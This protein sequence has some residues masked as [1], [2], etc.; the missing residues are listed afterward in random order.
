MRDRD[1]HQEPGVYQV[2]PL[3][4]EWPA[5]QAT[6]GGVGEVALDMSE[7]GGNGVAPALQTCV[8]PQRPA[9]GGS[10]H[11]KYIP[12]RWGDK[13]RVGDVVQRD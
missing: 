1:C 4:S 7:R 12:S 8:A 11:G 5:S 2:A 10:E 6:A 13:V 3:G 9:T